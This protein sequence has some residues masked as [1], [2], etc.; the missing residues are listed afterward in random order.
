VLLL[1]RYVRDALFMLALRSGAATLI[2]Q[3]G[4]RNMTSHSV[5]AGVRTCLGPCHPHDLS[6]HF[7]ASSCLLGCYDARPVRI[8]LWG[9]LLETR[10]RYNWQMGGWLLLLRGHCHRGSN[11]TTA[12][13][14]GSGRTP[15]NMN[16]P[17]FKPT[18]ALERCMQLA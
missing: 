16:I 1:R 3:P 11:L 18:P 15:T 5:P 14:A 2:L 10:R 6:H 4:L 17:R 8:G 13:A 9:P 7:P 12:I